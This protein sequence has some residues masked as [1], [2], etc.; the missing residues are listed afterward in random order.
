MAL[1][2]RIA[3]FVHFCALIA[4]V[5][6]SAL[7]H[8]GAARQARARLASEA[9]QWH[10]T[11]AKVELVFPIAILTFFASGGYMVHA[12]GMWR[13]S[14]GWI[15]DGMIGAGALFALGGYNGSRGRAF[16]ARLDEHARRSADAAPLAPDAISETI[17]W[18]CSG[19]ALAVVC[20]MTFKPGVVPGLVMLCSGLIAGALVSSLVARRTYRFADLVMNSYPDSSSSRSALSDMRSTRARTEV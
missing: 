3:L 18:M 2:Y 17:G 15:I 9:A 13:W 5:V 16:A 12:S 14:A 7:V 4:A 8:F 10:R 6:A 11:I 1:S 20:V 19:L